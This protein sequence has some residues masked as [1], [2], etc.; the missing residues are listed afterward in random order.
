M[1][2]GRSAGTR[3]RPGLCWMG[4]GHVAANVA[5]KIRRAELGMNQG[6]A[7]A[8]PAANDVEALT[9]KL[10]DEIADVILYLDLL[11][12]SRGINVGQAIIRKFNQKS[13]ECGF[14]ER[15]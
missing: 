3:A 10:A 11:A 8:P 13:E 1:R 5:K 6:G 14:P 4:G 12:A 9:D 2:R 7:G 15:L